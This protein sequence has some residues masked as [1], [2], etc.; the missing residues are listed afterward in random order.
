MITLRVKKD[1]WW[2]FRDAI[3]DLEEW[4]TYGS[5]RATS[6]FVPGHV[7]DECNCATLSGR[8]W[9]RLPSSYWQSV[10]HASYIV[11]SY[12]TPIAWRDY[13]T[14]EWLM[15]DEKYS[16]TTSFHQSKIFTAISEMIK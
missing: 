8:R 16:I 15:P 14:N 4:K 11:W 9:G 6:E 2:K 10:S 1:G 12:R 3:Q 5:L 13:W 7:Y